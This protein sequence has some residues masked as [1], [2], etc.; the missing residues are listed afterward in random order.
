MPFHTPH[1][2][3]QKQP[4]DHPL[5]RQDNTKETRA[6]TLTTQNRPHATAKITAA[7]NQNFG[8][9]NQ[10]TQKLAPIVKK[11]KNITYYLPNV[12]QFRK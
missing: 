5:L 2:S 1:T 10:N 4:P 8:Y 12:L 6:P 11:C 7:D 3:T 9:D